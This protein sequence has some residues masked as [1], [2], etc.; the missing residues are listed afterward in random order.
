MENYL[1]LCTI[2]LIIVGITAVFITLSIRRFQ[3]AVFF[4]VLAPWVSTLFNSSVTL[5]SGYATTVGEILRVYLVII[6]GLTG[7]IK[8]LQINRAE[9][10]KI[11]LQIKM[12]AAFILL[13]LLSVFYSVD[14]LHSLLTATTF[15]AL[16]GFL[17]GLY[18]W[19]MHGERFEIVLNSIFL[20]VVHIITTNFFALLFLNNEVWWLVNPTRF[21]GLWNHPEILGGVCLMTYPILLWKYFSGDALR[22][23]LPQGLP[24][25]RWYIAT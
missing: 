23:R 8:Y 14:Y 16:L 5:G 22:K 12:L 4:L 2:A 17:L 21:S 20:A 3:I 6:L 18:S 7:V 19:L 9:K 1:L 13:T 15:I 11:P 10:V 24:H 25:G